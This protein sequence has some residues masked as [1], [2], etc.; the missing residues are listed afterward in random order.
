[1]ISL[2]FDV[3]ELKLVK[4]QGGS[5]RFL[6]KK[7]G[8]GKVYSQV[9]KFL[10]KEKL[11]C[12]NDRVFLKSWV[13]KIKINNNHFNNLINK[14]IKKGFSVIGYGAPTKATLLL[15][16][17]NLGP[18]EISFIVDDNALKIDKYL[19]NGV[20]IKSFKEL[21]KIKGK[22]LIVILAWNFYEDI[23]NKLKL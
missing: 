9:K 14:K 19:Q 6:L 20:I 5:I 18:D 8:N 7:T 1:M 15:H 17:A 13:E 12:V 10:S 21:K 22:I 11:S 16:T 2:G 3:I 4:A 23:I